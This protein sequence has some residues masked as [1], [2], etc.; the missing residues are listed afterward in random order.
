MKRVI[1]GIHGL[2]R[3]PSAQVLHRWWL[4]SI[5]EG[6]SAI[7][8]PRRGLPFKT[9]YWAD[10]L[11]ATPYD[12]DILDRNDDRYLEDPYRPSPGGPQSVARPVRKKILDLVE[13]Q[14][15]RLDPEE[16]ISMVWKQFNDL[17]LRKFFV[18]LDAYYAN[19]LEIAPGAELAYRDIVRTRLADTLRKH[20]GREILL[21]AHSM[22][23]IIAYDVLS[24]RLPELKVHTLVTIGSPLG[25]PLVMHNIRLE[26][27][28]AKVE[29]LPTPESVTHH[30]FNLADLADKVALNY[31]LNDDFTPNSRGVAPADLEVY[32][33]Y[34]ID[35]DPNPHKAYGYLR[36]PELARICFDFISAGAPP[37]AIRRLDLLFKVWEKGSRLFSPR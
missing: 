8:H 25:M 28:L 5:Q 16:G 6:F 30:W 13:K 21:I 7:G 18:E 14:I 3:K 22:G 11:H 31:R 2:G 34:T 1:I 26:Q 20:S 10:I 37:A 23:S 17:V 4:K 33:D 35:G 12:P 36:T 19:S 29:K 15:M 32:N 27:E 9:V 24:S